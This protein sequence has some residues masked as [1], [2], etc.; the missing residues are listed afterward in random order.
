MNAGGPPAFLQGR[1]KAYRQMFAIA[2]AACFAL[3][4]FMLAIQPMVS[5]ILTDQHEISRLARLTPRAEQALSVET[6]VRET[7][8]NFE[9]KVSAMNILLNEPRAAIALSQV[10]DHIRLSAIEAGVEIAAL[11]PKPPRSSASLTLL[12]I[13]VEMSGT[14][15]AIA[16]LLF[17]L[18][19]RSPVLRFER[20]EWNLSTDN[21]AQTTLEA[22]LVGFAVEQETRE[23]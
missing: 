7:W 9:T 16:T 17:A 10:E 22:D 11:L 6:A 1:S 12:P 23:Q 8:G 20:I 21:L 15:S 5:A 13:S 18:E 2:L 14:S 3:A 19:N 4:V